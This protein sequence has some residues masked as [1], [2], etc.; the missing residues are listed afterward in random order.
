MAKKI[1]MPKLDMTMEEGEISSWLIKEGDQ[2][3]KG[4][5]IF[6]VLSEKANF[7][8]DSTAKGTVLKILYNEGDTVKVANPVAIV[9]KP[10]EDYSNLLEQGETNAGTDATSDEVD[11]KAPIDTKAT[12]FSSEN[13]GKT[14]ATPAAKTLAVSADISLSSVRPNEQG[15]VRKAQVESY[16]DSLTKTK[17]TPLAKK[18]AEEYNIDLS[19]ISGDQSR[20]YSGDVMAHMSETPVAP[21]EGEALRGIRKL[22]AKRLTE[23]WQQ[24]PMVTSTVE[25]DMFEALK[26]CQTINDRKKESDPKINVT[27]VLIKVMGVALKKVPEANIALVDGKIYHYTNANVSVAVAIEGGLT[28]PVIKDADQKGFLQ[29]NQEKRLLAQKAKEGT[30]TKEE[31]SGGCMTISNIGMFGV[32]IFT[33]I[34][35]TPES[36][37]LGVGRINKKPVV[38]EDDQ[39]VVRPMMWLSLTFDHRALDGVPAM[40]LLGSIRDMI[41]APNLLNY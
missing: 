13:D 17:S 11:E 36:T 40:K 20:I 7:E 35:N 38:I 6:E 18:M 22:S 28:V 21:I 39:I 12:S 14:A 10:G 16:L 27:D 19:T 24:V 15:V 23:T 26:M 3:V 33:P 34:I 5:P 8:I 4:Q 2:I 32:D 30:L 41:E 37:I 31:L 9:G 25:V 1:I 29:I